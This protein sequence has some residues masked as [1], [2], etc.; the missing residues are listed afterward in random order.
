M[1]GRFFL[2]VLLTLTIV[3]IV[4]DRDLESSIAVEPQRREAR[5]ALLKDAVEGQGP[6]VAERRQQADGQGRSRTHHERP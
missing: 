2:Q 3:Q 6:G 4:K 1:A 5:R